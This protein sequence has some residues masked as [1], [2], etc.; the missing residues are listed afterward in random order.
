MNARRVGIARDVSGIVA[1]VDVTN[2]EHLSEGQVLY[3]LDS[4]RFQ[5]ATGRAKSKLAQTELTLESM[6]S[7][8]M[9]EITAV[10]QYR[11]P[12]AAGG[13]AALDSGVGQQAQ[14]IALTTAS[15]R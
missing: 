12:F 7:D 11:N 14:I 5:I 6:K 10:T 13:R 8:C 4:R 2:N 1:N 3:R 15:C 9:F